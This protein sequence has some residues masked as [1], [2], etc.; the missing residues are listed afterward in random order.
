MT[1][2]TNSQLSMEALCELSMDRPKL[3]PNTCSWGNLQ[4]VTIKTTQS[5]LTMLL[6]TWR[7]M[8]TVEIIRWASHLSA[9]LLLLTKLN[10]R[11]QSWLNRLFR[12]PE[13]HHSSTYL[14]LKMNLAK[15][16]NEWKQASIQL[17]H[18]LSLPQ[19]VTLVVAQKAKRK[20]RGNLQDVLMHTTNNRQRGLDSNKKNLSLF[21]TWS[22]NTSK[23][24]ASNTKKHSHLRRSVQQAQARIE[25]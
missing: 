11:Q 19:G 7:R 25:S 2:C 24:T 9:T 15:V 6:A 18:Q 21:K 1:R 22:I 10:S 16:E 17:A 5:R 13:W 4:T 3:L 8:I 23:D 20:G 12:H 14:A